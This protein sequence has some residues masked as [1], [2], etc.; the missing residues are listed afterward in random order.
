MGSLDDVVLVQVVYVLRE[1][2]LDTLCHDV[3][4]CKCWRCIF[5]E[6]DGEVFLVVESYLEWVFGKGC[7]LFP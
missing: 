7:I 6:G 5:L 1:G 2:F 3:L 4:F